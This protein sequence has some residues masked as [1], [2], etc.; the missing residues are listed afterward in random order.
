MRSGWRTQVG[1]LEVGKAADFVV[2]DSPDED[3]WLY[4]FRANAALLTAVTGV[5]RWRA[6]GFREMRTTNLEPSEGSRPPAIELRR[7]S[8][9]RSNAKDS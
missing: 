3:H 1:S 8:R 6:P 5:V 2:I 4:H 9:L 7:Q